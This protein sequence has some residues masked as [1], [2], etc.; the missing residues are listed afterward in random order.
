MTTSRANVEGI[1]SPLFFLFI[2]F[3]VFLIAGCTQSKTIDQP[4]PPDNEIPVVLGP[5]SDITCGS[6]EFCFKGDCLCSEGFNR[7]NDIC[8][9]NQSCCTDKDCELTYFCNKEYTC[10]KGCDDFAC[11]R[12][13]I[14]DET[15][16]QCVCE[17]GTVWCENQRSC[18][19][20][21]SCCT[22]IDCPGSRDC[23]FTISFATMCI[24]SA[25]KV[26][27]EK[28]MEGQE[29]TFYVNEIKYKLFIKRIYD[30]NSILLSLNNKAIMLFPE[31]EY[32]V[33]DDTIM[34]VKIMKNFGG[35]CKT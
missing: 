10:E 20:E 26:G 29:N 22:D 17:P 13:K 21:G 30:D 19:K 11:E 25:G 35:E 6:N 18:L 4:R 5:C 3:L 34:Y 15:S 1:K 8:I 23:V 24:E 32:N 31:E 14:C 16:K 33:D 2:L 28:I 9:S 27:C 12:N 7:C